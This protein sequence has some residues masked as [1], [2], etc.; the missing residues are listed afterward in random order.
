MGDYS[1]ASRSSK[2]GS[3]VKELD[4]SKKDKDKDKDKKDKK[5]GIRTPSFLRKK[6]HKKDKEREKNEA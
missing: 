2:E 4:K 3:P 1:G 5:K 6:K